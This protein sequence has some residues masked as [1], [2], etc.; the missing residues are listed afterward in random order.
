MPRVGERI[1]Y[2]NGFMYSSGRVEGKSVE[3]I[4]T[5]EGTWQRKTVYYVADPMFGNVGVIRVDREEAERIGSL[6]AKV[7]VDLGDAVFTVSWG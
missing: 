2:W 6:Y 7:E 3:R 5:A 1:C 4:P